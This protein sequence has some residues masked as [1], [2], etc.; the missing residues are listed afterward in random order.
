MQ[1]GFWVIPLGYKF[2]LTSSLFHFESEQEEY[3]CIWIFILLCSGADLCVF[4]K[5]PL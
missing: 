2:N 4:K 5:I 1:A 3:D